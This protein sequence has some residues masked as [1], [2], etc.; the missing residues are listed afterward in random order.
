ML[1]SGKVAYE[2]GGNL[3]ATCFGGIAAVHRLV[4]K[5]GLVDQINDGL[6][7]LK[8]HLPYH[9]SDHVLNL[10]YNVM[11]GGTRLEDIERLRHDTAY[12]N[13]LGADLIPDPTTAGDFCRRFAEDDV[14]ELMEAINAVR[15]Q[16]WTGRGGDLL[17]PIAYIDA[18]GTIAPTSGRRKAGM[19]MSYNRIWGYAPLIVSLANTK[20]VLYLVNRP[21]NA[22]SHQDAASWIDK[23]IDLVRPH[24]DR[25]CLRGDTDFSLTANF[26]RWANKVD[27]IFGM[28]NNTALR[29]RAEALA[30]T[31]WTRMRRDTPGQNATG[32]TRAR[33]DNHKQAI[34]AER[35]YLNLELNYEDV[36]CFDYQPGKCDRSYRVVALRKNISRSRGEQVLID[37]V[38]YFFYITT[39]TDLTAE[40]VVACAN[41]RC[42]QENIIASLKSGVGALRVPLHDLVSNWAYMVIAALAW[43]IK[44]WFAMMMHR[45]ADRRDYIRMEFRRFFNTIILIPAIVTRRARAITIRLIGYNPALDRLFSAWNT[46]ERTRFG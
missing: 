11:C 30:Q 34:V 12:M 31:C 38:R 19:D 2:V 7:L 1:T 36:A 29:A 5:L 40:Q 16:L 10:T 25:V 22:P 3:D 18:D 21:G 45:K 43:N 13:A 26:D 28:D 37:E 8:V 15:P 42:D 6:H 23:A 44:S 14:V 9:E 35:G 17:A 27:F 4:T 41:Q 24:A 20:E 39:R 32:Q 33:R 46:T